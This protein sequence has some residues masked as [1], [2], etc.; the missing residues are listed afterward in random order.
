MRKL[1]LLLPLAFCL[2]LTHVYSQNQTNP[3]AF[4]AKLNAIDYGLLFNSK[5]H[6]G[7]QFEFGY[8]RNVAPN[9]NLGI[10]VKL[11]LAK[12]ADNNVN[13][14]ITSADFMLRF[15]NMAADSKI[16]PFAFAG[17]GY[18]LEDFDNGHLQFP[19][20]GGVHFLVS[21]NTYLSLQ[22][23]YR[24]SIVADRDN[25]Q[26]GLGCVYLFHIA[27]KQPVKPPVK[28]VLVSIDDDKDGVIN[29]LDKCPN[30]A[31]P[32]ATLG[33]PDRDSDGVADA[34]DLCPDDAG[35][36]ETKGCPDYDKDGLADANDD[37]P[38]EAGTIK[39]C[40]DTDFDGVP[41]KDDKCPTV[42]GTLDR[43]GCPPAVDT[44]G[45]GLMD[46]VD[47]CPD[48]AG[49]LKGCPDADGDGVAD[50]DDKCPN[51]AGV[52]SNNGCPP[53][54]DADK[55]G[56][57]D[58][59]D[60][61]P[62][63]AG[64]ASNNGCPPVLDA[65]KDGILDKDDKCP[66]EAG[67]AANNGCPVRDTDGDGIPD[68]DDKCPNEAGTTANNGCPVR[69]ADGDGIADKDDKCPNEAG[70][71]K[72]NGCPMRDADGDG[73]TDKDDKCPN[74]A[75]P[76]SNMGCPI[77]DADGDGITD[78]D[79]KCPNEAGTA[80]NKGCPIRDADNDGFTDD[81]DSCPTVA[82]SLRGC[83][84][85]DG[86]G[87][88][89]KDDKCPNKPG[90]A[91][92]NGCPVLASEPDRDGDGVPDKTD[93]CPDKAGTFGGCLDTDGDKVADNIDKCPA[94]FGPASNFGCPE[95]K[96]EVKE[97]LAYAARAVQFE[98][99]RAIL[100]N[101]SYDILDE[102]V[103][104][105]RENPAYTLSISGYTDDI[106]GEERNLT[107]SQDRAKT[108]YDYLVFRGIKTERLRHA[109]F[110]ESRPI[111]D[112]LTAEGRD[113]NRRVEFELLLD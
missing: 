102:I 26:F 99:G 5:V 24:K 71:L 55:D 58:K 43:K 52:A 92:N 50:K 109:G 86:D 57:L 100:K 45:D 89:D 103:I 10:P 37:C 105:M 62:N 70:T 33:C 77:R 85:T 61:C 40:P 54:L 113:L 22:A 60:K 35:A 82:G 25:L 29:K 107:L 53:V 75:G 69:D 20:G 38:T 90:T 18:V 87:V 94:E 12:L 31:G 39:G 15:E 73:I 80:A 48:A 79:D 46:D 78:K 6:V 93:P 51:E 91:N 72:N 34:A 104:I 4:H 96:K 101:Q 66:N 41:N 97:R 68:K 74:E 110:G 56:I 42:P 67:T 76:V 2:L 14:V 106:G 64:V 108:C 9:I 30:E 44:D 7:Q 16:V 83:P 32:A 63:E 17:A 59:D 8:F 3:N 84:D 28:P 88:A 112:N 47:L 21:K 98:T 65:D 81:T 49:K 36:V 13:T 23:E 19:L 111:A 11:G 27:E 95:V 1:S